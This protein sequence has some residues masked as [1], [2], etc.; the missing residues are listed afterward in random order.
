MFGNAIVASRIGD[1]LDLIKDE[2]NGLLAQLDD[3][4]DFA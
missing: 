4:N 3:A 1:I 2:R